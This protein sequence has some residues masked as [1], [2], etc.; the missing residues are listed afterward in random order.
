MRLN[1]GA[2][3]QG[4]QGLMNALMAV[5]E[6]VLENLIC[7]TL[8]AKSQAVRGYAWSHAGSMANSSG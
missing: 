1:G 3:E 8:K 5:I 2:S 6:A 4:Q 7:S